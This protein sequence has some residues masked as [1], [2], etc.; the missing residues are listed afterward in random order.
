MENWALLWIASAPSVTLNNHCCGFRHAD[1]LLFREAGSMGWAFR[2]TPGSY[3]SSSTILHVPRGRHARSNRP[4]SPVRVLLHW[5][6]FTA[7]A[8]CTMLSNCPDGSEGCVGRQYRRRQFHSNRKDH[9]I[10]VADAPPSRPQGVFATSS[11][12]VLTTDRGLSA[13]WI[14][15]YRRIAVQ[16][17]AKSA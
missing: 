15:A 17:G 11:S 1:L 9:H 4:F 6:R 7:I 5:N 13:T 16:G 2:R 8:H 3:V 12:G 10:F 14:Q